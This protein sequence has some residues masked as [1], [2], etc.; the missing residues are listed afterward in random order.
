MTTIT[1]YWSSVLIGLFIGVALMAIV[2][3][4][5]YYGKR[6]DDGFSYG[7]KCGESYALKCDKERIVEEK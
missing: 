2:V 7:W 3:T 6:W 5:I 1:V 4:C